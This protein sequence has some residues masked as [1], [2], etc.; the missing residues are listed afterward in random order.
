[1]KFNFIWKKIKNKRL[2]LFGRI[3]IIPAKV[4]LVLLILFV[5]I[6]LI[7]GLIINHKDIV[8]EIKPTKYPTFTGSSVFK[9]EEAFALP[10]KGISFTDTYDNSSAISDSNTDLTGN[11]KNFIQIH[12]SG[13]VCS[14]GVVS[15]S[16]NARL[17]DVIEAA[18]GL[19]E[20]SDLSFINLASFVSDGSK[21]Y[22]PFIGETP[23]F[24]ESMN[25]P[26]KVES[27]VGHNYESNENQLNKKININ[28][29]TVTQLCTLS[30]I[31]QSTAKKI[32]AYREANGDFKKIEDILLV[33]G[34]GESKFNNIKDFIYV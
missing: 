27:E 11:N 25:T 32:I 34:I 15:V 24:I 1:M 23:Y 19:K 13:A 12:I 9:T 20:K 5:L 4:Q 18:G 16:E 21:I 33:S 10:T 14:P 6:V 7:S 2:H 30:G 22:I 8:E 17:A 26:T 3:F 28:T 29:A 31:G